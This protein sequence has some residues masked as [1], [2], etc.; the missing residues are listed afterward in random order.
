MLFV[1]ELLSGMDEDVD[2]PLN[3]DTQSLM[4]AINR[5]TEDRK[6][7]D[8]AINR[9]QGLDSSTAEMNEA[10]Q[11]VERYRKSFDENHRKS[12]DLRASAFRKYKESQRNMRR[13]HRRLTRANRA[14]M[15]VAKRA[16][17][18]MP[19]YSRT[20]YRGGPSLCSFFENR[21]LPRPQPSL[22]AAQSAYNEADAQDTKACATHVECW[23]TK[24]TASY[25]NTSWMLIQPLRGYAS[26][27]IGTD[28]SD[29]D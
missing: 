26:S 9:L 12:E 27:G 21:N 25:G 19:V 6:M 1:H 14:L 18:K 28:S 5:T 17:R 16:T 4:H 20:A 8:D 2:E 7:L 22:L 29:S 15:I 24:K 3:C 10:K 11:Q 23:Q 13:A